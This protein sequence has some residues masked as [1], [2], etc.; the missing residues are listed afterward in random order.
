MPPDSAWRGC[1]TGASQGFGANSPT[2]SYPLHAPGSQGPTEPAGRGRSTGHALSLPR[3]P[4]GGAGPLPAASAAGPPGGAAL[5]PGCGHRP[6]PRRTGGRLGAQL[7][8]SWSPAG[9]R[10]PAATPCR[11]LRYGCY[12]SRPAE[13]FLVS[14][15]CGWKEGGIEADGREPSAPLKPRPHSMRPMA[16]QPAGVTSGQSEV[17]LGRRLQGC[18]R[19]ARSA[20]L[21]RVFPL[22]CCPRHASRVFWAL[23]P[24]HLL[25]ASTD[26]GPPDQGRP[27]PGA[28]ESTKEIRVGTWQKAF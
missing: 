27:G 6:G 22:S 13:G 24:P 1:P 10:Q 15:P 17:S 12:S 18:Q 11:S 5:G 8:R 2:P 16:A 21:A 20:L 4:H 23:P 28:S 7:T 25:W 26:L 14:D 19:W 3:Q 9:C